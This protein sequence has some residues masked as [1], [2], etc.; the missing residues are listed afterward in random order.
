MMKGWRR[1][2]ADSLARAID[3][4]GVELFYDGQD[5]KGAGV[6]FKRPE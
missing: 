5:G 4:A 6:R 2:M 1:M 3:R